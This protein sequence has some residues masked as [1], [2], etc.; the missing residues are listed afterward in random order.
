VGKKV[1]HWSEVST[2]ESC[3]EQYRWAYFEEAAPE[4]PT[5]A[6]SVGINTHA[7]IEAQLTHKLAHDSLMTEAA[8]R[9]VCVEKVRCFHK[10]QGLS[11]SARERQTFS[12]KKQ[13]L[14]HVRENVVGLSLLFHRELAP[15]IEPTRLPH[16]VGVE[17]DWKVALDDYPFDVGG[18]ID[19][20]QRDSIID[21]KTTSRPMSQRNADESGQ[22]TI[23]SLGHKALMGRYP[24]DVRII[25]LVRREV[26]VYQ[27]LHTR[28]GPKDVAALLRRYAAAY[29]GIM[30][31][32]FEPSSGWW[33]LWCR[34]KKRCSVKSE[35]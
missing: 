8:I 30:A 6:L 2:W 5:I 19:V 27:V 11:L 9:D 7:V 17:M 25:N 34:F 21:I 23:Y 15:S 10:Q 31:G 1:L 22:L 20:N 18:I 26:P 3:P 4:A 12:N 33:C 16:A 35:T 13:A 28:R 14:A 32:R 24:K 29:E